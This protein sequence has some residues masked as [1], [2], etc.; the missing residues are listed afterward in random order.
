MQCSICSQCR[1]YQPHQLPVGTVV[2]LV[3]DDF[4]DWLS[5]L[6]RTNRFHCEAIF[7]SALYR[8]TITVSSSY[9]QRLLQRL[10]ARQSKGQWDSLKYWYFLKW[11]RYVRFASIQ[12]VLIDMRRSCLNGFHFLMT[13]IFVSYHNS[14][15]TNSRFTAWDKSHDKVAMTTT[16]ILNRSQILSS[17]IVSQYFWYI[18]GRVLQQYWCYDSIGYL[19]GYLLAFV[20]AKFWLLTLVSIY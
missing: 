8:K 16:I 11:C 15:T 1:G 6:L 7:L 2:V 17:F 12:N 20:N 14:S 19:H 5:C 4:W 3:S 13:S 9:Q 18:S 10:L